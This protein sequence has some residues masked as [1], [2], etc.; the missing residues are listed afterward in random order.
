[1]RINNDRLVSDRKTLRLSLTKPNLNVLWRISFTLNYVTQNQLG[2]CH[3]FRKSRI[4]LLSTNGMKIQSN[5]IIIVDKM[6]VYL[7]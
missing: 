7:K 2:R 5:E 1:M 3:S 6:G 4:L